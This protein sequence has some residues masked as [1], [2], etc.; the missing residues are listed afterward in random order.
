M[1]STLAQCAVVS[2]AARA[3]RRAPA[4]VSSGA[5]KTPMARRAVSVS[6]GLGVR[7]RAEKGSGDAGD[8]AAAT[9]TEMGKGKK[10]EDSKNSEAKKALTKALAKGEPVKG[11][12]EVANRGGLILRVF[13][14][15][16]RAFLPLSQMA[17]SRTLKVKSTRITGPT[18]VTAP[19][20][21]FDDEEE[22]FVPVSYTHLT[23]PT[24][25]LV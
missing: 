16:F 22:D 23:L 17:S 13:N 15:R 9:A 19:L 2:T 7:A 4:R 20:A 21:S 3:S 24:I 25:L 5:P 14:G 12:V 11:R 6:R 1:A 8:A 18:T 10:A